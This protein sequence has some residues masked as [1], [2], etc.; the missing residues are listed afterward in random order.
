MAYGSSASDRLASVRTAIDKVLNS[1]EYQTAAGQRNK[2]AELK[3]LREMERELQE[4]VAQESG[5]M[6][7][8]GR[9]ERE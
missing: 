9:F 5:S 2:Y 8:V 4:E 3:T 7:S 6:V 1:Q